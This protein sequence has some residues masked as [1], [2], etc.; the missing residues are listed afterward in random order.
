MLNHY[1]STGT[2]LVHMPRT[3]NLHFARKTDTFLL[4]LPGFLCK[5]NKKTY[6]CYQNNNKA[7]I[8]QC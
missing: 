4:F 5:M 3:W 2:R 8:K 7:K 6:F 1:F